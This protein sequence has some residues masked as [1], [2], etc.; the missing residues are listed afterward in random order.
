M[1]VKLLMFVRMDRETK[2][3]KYYFIS[4]NQKDLFQMNKP[5]S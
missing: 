5:W 1:D 3:L 2:K 4:G